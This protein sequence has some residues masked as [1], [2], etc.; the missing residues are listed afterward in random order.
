MITIITKMRLYMKKYPISEKDNELIKMA[1]KVL[2]NNFDDSPYNHTVVA[3]IRCSNGNIYT[4]VNCYAIHGSCAEYITIGMAMSAGER[5][6]DVIVAVHE[7]APNGLLSPCGNCRQMLFDYYP[8]IKI[9]L[10]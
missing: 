10:N 4:G 6:Y 2:E 9:I 3:G 7:K 1:L 5:V 8:N